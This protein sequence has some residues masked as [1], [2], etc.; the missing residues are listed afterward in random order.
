MMTSERGASSLLE[1][2]DY[3]CTLAASAHEVRR[4]FPSS[5][6]QSCPRNPLGEMFSKCILLGRNK[7]SEGLNQCNEFVVHA[8]SKI[9]WQG[10]P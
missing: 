4:S 7:T 5:A 6:A 8:K 9:S 3:A 2:G 10:V 1:T